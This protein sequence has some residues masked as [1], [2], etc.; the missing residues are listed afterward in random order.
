M[1]WI[2]EDRVLTHRQQQ[3]LDVLERAG[4]PIR[5]RVSASIKRLSDEV[6]SAILNGTEWGSTRYLAKQTRAVPRR[7]TKFND[8]DRRSVRVF[9][10]HAALLALWVGGDVTHSQEKFERTVH[11]THHVSPQALPLL[12]N[13]AAFDVL[14]PGE[15]SD[16]LTGLGRYTGPYAMAIVHWLR[17]CGK[18]DLK[19]WSHRLAKRLPGDFWRSGNSGCR[20]DQEPLRGTG[21]HLFNK[22]FEDAPR[23]IVQQYRGPVIQAIAESTVL[24]SLRVHRG[25]HFMPSSRS[26]AFKPSVARQQRATEWL[27]T[28]IGGL[29]PQARVDLI[30]ALAEPFKTVSLERTELAFQRVTM[31]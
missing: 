6:A 18:Q 5:G 30:L 29:E 12:V 23:N 19:E 7:A 9:S 22:V 11:I 3:V 28:A 20:Y 4:L 26:N 27:D 10:P 16:L 13:T 14:S 24:F 2:K 21:L 25:E 17:G 8:H 15:R 1:A 31:P